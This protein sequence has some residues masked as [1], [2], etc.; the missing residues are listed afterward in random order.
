SWPAGEIMT[1]VGLTC[2]MIGA[3]S[4]NAMNDIAGPA[5]A[6]SLIFVAYAIS[7]RSADVFL[8][9]AGE[10]SWIDDAAVSGS[11]PRVDVQVTDGGDFSASPR[12]RGFVAKEWSD[13]FLSRSGW[14]TPVS[15][16][17]S[18]VDLVRF[19]KKWEAWHGSL[20]YTTSDCIICPKCGG[21]ML[22]SDVKK[23][24]W[25]YASRSGSDE[26]LSVSHNVARHPW[27]LSNEW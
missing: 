15:D 14:S 26:R 6:A 12:S 19:R 1:A 17:G 24:H 16:S 25:F 4:G 2:A 11:S 13:G 22:Q 3:L 20:G 7:G 8:E 5:A 21:R 10:I 9:K 18:G 23:A 27:R